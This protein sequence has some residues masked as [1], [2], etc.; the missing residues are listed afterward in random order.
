MTLIAA[1][2][3]L[4]WSC[5]QCVDISNEAFTMVTSLHKVYQDYAKHM[6]ETHQKFAVAPDAL[7]QNH[8]GFYPGGPQ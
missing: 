3:G 5:D 6:Q 2:G 7:S 4:R 8:D 1:P